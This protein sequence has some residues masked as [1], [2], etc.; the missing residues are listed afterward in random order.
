M[1]EVKPDLA[2]I[3]CTG[4]SENLDEDIANDIGIKTILVKPVTINTLINWINKT[5]K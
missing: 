3:I 5:L 4:F 1:L 2:I